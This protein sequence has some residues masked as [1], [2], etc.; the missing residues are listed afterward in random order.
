M[1]ILKQTFDM[2][3]SGHPGHWDAKIADFG[4][5]A[6]VNARHNNDAMQHM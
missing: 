4:L 5:H 2:L 6:T 3:R 1:S